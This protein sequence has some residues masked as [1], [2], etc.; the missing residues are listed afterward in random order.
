MGD[1]RDEPGTCRSRP[2]W[3][4][5]RQ[6]QVGQLRLA[7]RRPPSVAAI[8]RRG[9]ANGCARPS[10]AIDETVT[11]EGRRRA[12]RSR[13]Q[14]QPVSAK[15]PRWFV[16]NCISKPSAVRW[17]GYGHHP[18]VVDETIEPSTEES[19]S[20]AHRRTDDRSARSRGTRSRRRLGCRRRDGVESG[21]RLL[22]VAAR[23]STSRTGEGQRL[24]GAEARSRRWRRS[25]G[26]CG[27]PGPGC[28]RWSSDAISRPMRGGRRRPRCGPRATGGS[29]AR[30]SGARP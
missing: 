13:G 25:P 2:P 5:S 6:E 17:C 22:T 23:R 30:G 28:R 20:A 19:T 18:G 4:S 11:G 12:R 27:R 26:W 10:R 1:H 29:G 7:V 21:G 14:E 8:A 16:P 24:C 9:L 3:N 15:W